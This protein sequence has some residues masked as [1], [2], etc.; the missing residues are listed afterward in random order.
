MSD[1]W[2]DRQIAAQAALTDK[3]IE[4]TEKQLRKYYSQT[5]RTVMDGFEDAYNR[6]VISAMN[7]GREPTPADLYKLDTYWKLQAELA[8]E[9]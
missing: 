3:S 7:E 2:K 6:I 8:Q 1:Y 9:L 4:E 5:M